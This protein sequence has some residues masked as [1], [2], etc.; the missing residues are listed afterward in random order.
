M[1]LRFRVSHLVYS[2]LLAALIAVVAMQVLFPQ[3]EPDLDRVLTLAESRTGPKSLSVD[4]GAPGLWQRLLRLQTVASVLYTTAHPDDEQGGT[5]TYLS[6]GQGVRTSL[7]TLNRGES[8]ANAIGPE[9]FDGVGLIRTEE[10]LVSNRY[11][12]LDDQ[13]FTTLID[14][15]YSKNLDEALRQWGKENVL[16]DVV[17]VIRINRPLVLVARFYGGTRDGHGNH[18]TA[19]V[20]TQEAFELAGDPNQF[21]EQ[22]SDEGL[23]PW[24][25]LKV[26][27]GNLRSRS[28]RQFRGSSM[29]PDHRWNV[30]VNVG[31]FSPWLGESYQEFSAL[32][33]SFQ[34]SQNSGRRSDRSGAHHQFF[35]RVNSRVEAPERET[36]FFDG[37][38]T[39]ISAIYTLA[40]TTPPEGVS[41]LLSEIESRV[42]DSVTAYNVHNPGAVVPYLVQGLSLTREAIEL[43]EGHQEALF[44][45]TIKERQ[46]QDAINTA[47]GLQFRAVAAPLGS[48]TPTSP[49][50]RPAATGVIVPGQEFQVNVSLVN[51]S[52]LP[53]QTERISLGGTEKWKIDGDRQ[54]GKSLQSG[55]K[56]VT[57]FSV[58]TPRDATLS[59]RYF[60]RGSIQESRYQVREPEHLHLAGREP[61][62]SASVDYLIEGQSVR[63][64]GVVYRLEANLPYGYE[65]RELKIAPALVVNVSPP[66][67][68]VPLGSTTNQ[69]SLEVELLNN[70]I[71]G[72]QGELS[73]EV[74]KGWSAEPRRQAFQFAQANAR[75]N[76]SFSVSVPQLH[77]GIYDLQVVARAGGQDYRQGYQAIRYR[78]YDIRYLYRNSVT[79]VRGVDVKIAPDLKVGYL[80]GVGDEVP[81]G[82][83]Q[84]GAQVTLLDS[85]DLAT[86]DLNDYGTIVVGT[87]AY[88][89][90]QDLITYNQRL[91]DYAHQGGNL[92]ILYQTQEFVPGK[93]AAFPA[94]L[95][96][97]AQEVSE[98]DSP[99]KIL[100]A[101]H[102]VFGG[103][104][105]ITAA[106]FDNWVEQRGSKFFSS[107]DEAYVPMI[108]TQDQGQEP[109][110]GGWV[111]AQYGQG[112]YTYFAYAVHR[113]LPYSVPGA[114]RIFANLLSLG[115]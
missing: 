97:R 31:T 36:G 60:H 12:G 100:A 23:S 74:P 93:W 29:P 94:D 114:Y 84:M 2:V 69:V 48:E 106:D 110:R 34:R 17:R 86:G 53:I 82:I 63:A 54:S 103:P 96:R 10:L 38:D 62:L 111:T 52:T 66:N 50:S 5:L 45:L 42:A 25:P 105:Q 88:A 79:Q 81:S 13:Y 101:D 77:E 28:S 43:S 64:S 75:R 72:I 98:E 46:F 95:P 49:F 70:Q 85:D 56:L 89:V 90:R 9:L 14:Y 113:Q 59:R 115:H 20:V 61:A 3:S 6:R 78:D 47:L 32:G 55:E 112:Y 51:P 24:Q 8:G 7:L 108:E 73:L 16:R 19:G 18:Q 41:N 107:W 37:I 104:N 11:Y 76:F 1:R 65:H 109:Q 99:V 4:R 26:Y 30:D 83:E 33:L 39:S 58:S 57:T 44:L 67:L 40:G 102:A 22:I 15:G 68:I 71:G 91:L 87:R 80:M 27:R 92:I 21:P 35:E